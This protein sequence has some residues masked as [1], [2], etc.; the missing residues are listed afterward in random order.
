MSIIE[1]IRAAAHAGDLTR[2]RQRLNKLLVVAYDATHEAHHYLAQNATPAIREELALQL[3]HRMERV[4]AASRR[5]INAAT[6]RANIP[7][8][9]SPF[10]TMT[11]P[12]D[13][14]H[15][16]WVDV[17]RRQV[18][19][20]A[21]VWHA[22]VADDLPPDHYED[23][24]YEF[25][26]VEYVLRTDNAAEGSRRVAALKAHA[27]VMSRP[28]DRFDGLRYHFAHAILTLWLDGILPA[29]L[30]ALTYEAE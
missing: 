22:E 30:Y 11:I 9:A 8:P 7:L 25:V 29:R 12:C 6:W 23:A 13:V 28:S 21:W 4:P 24:L 18:F 10:I 15:N 5:M 3:M 27:G 26:D 20:L 14:A 17:S 19:A 2:I 1:D 16:L